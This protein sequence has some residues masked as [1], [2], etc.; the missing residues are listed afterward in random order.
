MGKTNLTVSLE[1]ATAS[2]TAEP[3][4]DEEAERARRAELRHARDL[5]AID[6]L[7]EKV[8][9]Q[10]ARLAD[11]EAALAAAIAAAAA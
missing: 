6:R 4:F 2:A 10:R 1:P 5:E 8:A 7:T 9:N 11:A 3:D